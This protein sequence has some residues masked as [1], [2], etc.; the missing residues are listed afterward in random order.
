M[1]ISQKADQSFHRTK[2]DAS[3]NAL[4]NT[5]KSL[6]SVNSGIAEMTFF[7]NALFRIELH[8]SKWAGFNTS[9]AFRYFE[10]VNPPAL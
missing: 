3:T 2:I 5:G 7:C 4:I 8:H 10:L 9:L 6:S 1:F